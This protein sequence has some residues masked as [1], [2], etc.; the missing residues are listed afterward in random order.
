M[1]DRLIAPEKAD[2]LGDARGLAGSLR[3]EGFRP[4]SRIAATAAPKKAA[5]RHD[6]ACREERADGRR[7]S[8]GRRKERVPAVSAK[9]RANR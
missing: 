5:R 3:D 6:G 8:H 1:T 9:N 2:V 4:S 7:R